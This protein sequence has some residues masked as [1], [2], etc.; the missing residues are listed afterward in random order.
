MEAKDW[1]GEYVGLW[2][3]IILTYCFG[4]P[5]SFSTEEI[6]CILFTFNHWL[7]LRYDKRGKSTKNLK[8]VC[9]KD[10]SFVLRISMQIMWVIESGKI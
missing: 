5:F 7:D 6:L 2:Q 3:S 9:I 1:L 4:Y 8:E 10:A